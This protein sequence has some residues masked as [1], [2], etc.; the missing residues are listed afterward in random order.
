MH[1]DLNPQLDN[2]MHIRQ[3][4]EGIAEKLGEVSEW[5]SLTD[6]EYKLEALDG[7]AH[8]LE[9]HANALEDTVGEIGDELDEFN[10]DEDVDEELEEVALNINP[11]IWA[12]HQ[13]PHGCI[14]NRL[15][16]IEKYLGLHD[17]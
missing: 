3:Q 9:E 12:E 17:E 7:F 4:L 5:D 10:N 6:L 13:T 16:R 14:A 11:S 1:L 15:L 8:E 2:L